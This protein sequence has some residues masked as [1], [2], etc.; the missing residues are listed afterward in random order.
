MRES[1]LVFREGLL[2]G[3]R[4]SERN[5]RNQA[6][7]TI[8]NGLMPESGAFRSVPELT[9][10]SGITA[11]GEVFPFP[12]VHVGQAHT[13]VMGATTI[14]ELVNG[15]LVQKLSGL[16]IGSIWTVADF[17]DYLILTNGVIMV[18]RN[19]DSHTW[20]V[21]TDENIPQSNCVAA[22][23]GQLIVGSPRR[24]L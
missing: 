14:W 10:M 20:E 9:N 22:V 23:N 3:L 1:E 24:A 17:Y 2:K 12:Q 4:S 13:I 6:A 7:L 16:T 5:P 11:L 21:F 19:A 15:S 18:R 8:S